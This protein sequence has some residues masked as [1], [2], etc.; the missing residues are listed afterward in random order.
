MNQLDW[1]PESSCGFRGPLFPQ[2][3]F[4]AVDA[5]RAV[6]RWTEDGRAIS[7]YADDYERNVMHVHPGLVEISSFANFRRQMREYGFDWLYHPETREFEFSHPSF[8]RDRPDL[9]QE[10]LTRRKRRRRHGVTS[11]VGTRAQR[12]VAVPRRCSVLRYAAA[13]QCDSRQRTCSRASVLRDVGTAKSLDEM[14][15]EEWWTY[16][17]PA[18]ELGMNGVTDDVIN[19]RCRMIEN[20]FITPLFFYSDEP[21]ECTDNTASSIPDGRWTLRVLNFDEL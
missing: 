20:R 15:D 2:K 14:T 3:L 13:L 6:V 7:V 8:C 10:V 19:G 11:A 21:R 5:P 12:R 18:I 1:L 17:A 4:D 9:L 16:C